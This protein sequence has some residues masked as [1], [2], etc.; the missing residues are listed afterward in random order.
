MALNPNGG[1]TT[2]NEIWRNEAERQQIDREI[3]RI[4]IGDFRRSKA[5]VGAIDIFTDPGL[6]GPDA[7]TGWLAG[8]SFGRGID[9]ARMRRGFGAGEYSVPDIITSR[10]AAAQ[11]EFYEIK[12]DSLEGRRQGAEKIAKFLKLN[13]DFQ[14]LFFPGTEYDPIRSFPFPSIVM[15]GPAEYEIELRWF[16][17][18]PSLILYEICYKKR[19]KQEQEEHMSIPEWLFVILLGLI[20]LIILKGKMPE[21]G[22]VGPPIVA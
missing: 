13:N 2:P 20:L 19:R 14:L 16:R 7:L 21:I 22:P 9:V 8:H 18:A 12:P 3:E 5:A 10:G 1:C 4:I 17:S 11:S 15:I 6:G